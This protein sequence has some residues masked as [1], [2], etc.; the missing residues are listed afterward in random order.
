MYLI[1]G[2]TMTK[3]QKTILTAILLSEASHVFCC[4]LP[5]VFSILS[6][7]GS[8]GLIV[9]MPGWMQSLHTTMHGYEV[10]M[11]ILS[12]SVVALGWALHYYAHH[13]NK[14]QTHNHTCCDHDHGAI[15]KAQTTHKILIAA[16]VLLIIN[17]IIYFAFHRNQAA[18]EHKDKSGIA[19]VHH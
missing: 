1:Q 4:V 13:L 7:L 16:S 2:N 3:H 10:P 14:M 12:A 8:F 17:L 11:I 18:W 9:A 5:T 6:L 15:P 19:E